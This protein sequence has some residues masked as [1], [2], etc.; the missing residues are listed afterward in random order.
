MRRIRSKWFLLSLIALVFFYVLYIFIMDKRLDYLYT[1]GYI[2]LVI[3]LIVFSGSLVGAPGLILHGIF[4]NEKLAMPFYSLAIKLGSSNTNVLIAYGLVMLRSHHPE[5]A[6][7]VFQQAKEVSRHFFYQKALSTNI[8]LCHWKLGDTTLA[9]KMYEDI[10]YYPDLQPITDFTL[11]NLEEGVE[12]NANF[13]AQDFIT[14]G[15]L[16]YLN[17]HIEKALYFSHVGLKK[18][19]KYGPAYDNLGQIAFS[20]GDY[21]LAKEYFTQGLVY[22]PNMTDSIYYMALIA[23]NEGDYPRSKSI[24]E[25]LNRAKINGLSTITLEN[26]ESLEKKLS[27]V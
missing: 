14:L 5:K 16:E 7:I 26:V 12:K 2:Y 19:E 27:L 22:K 24:L 18:S 17:G 6:L 9:A 23:Y 1:T 15:F 21:N 20:Q 8:A 11:D 13:T 25:S 4:K 3:T 10:Y